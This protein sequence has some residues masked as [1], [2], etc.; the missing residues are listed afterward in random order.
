MACKK[1]KTGIS[2]FKGREA[3][4]NHVIL[5]ILIKNSPQIIYDISKAVRQ[6]KG[7]TNTKYTNVNRRV[8][9]L[10]QQGFLEKAGYRHTQQGAQSTLFQ[11]TARA[12]VAL[13]L[14]RLDLNYFIN[15]ADESILMAQLATLSLFFEKAIKKKKA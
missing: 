9:A 13:Y 15:E 8:K 6:Q 7:L 4:L 10:E 5:I 14:S 11:P 2:V 1:T 3:K 12:Y